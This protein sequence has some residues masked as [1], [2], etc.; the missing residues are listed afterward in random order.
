[1]QPS[2]PGARFPV[3]CF[4]RRLP[5][6]RFH[7]CKSTRFV[8]L[9]SLSGIHDQQARPV[10]NGMS[11]KGASS[12]SASGGELLSPCRPRSV[13][14]LAPRRPSMVRPAGQQVRTHQ[15][16]ILFSAKRLV[17]QRREYE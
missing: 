1:M 9:L 13:V 17:R 10:F 2:G 14:N 6:L 12:S 4:E 8:Q 16:P 15:F 11:W 3:S 5:S 7:P